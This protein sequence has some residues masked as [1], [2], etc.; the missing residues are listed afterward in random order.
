MFVAVVIAAAVSAASPVRISGV[1][2]DGY[3]QGTPEP[4]SAIRLTNTD[5]DHP[6]PLGGYVLTERLTPKKKTAAL[7]TT[8]S[9][10]SNAQGRERERNDDNPEGVRF[11]Q[12]AVIPPGGELWI[13]ATA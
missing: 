6:A 11:P 12:G 13:A 2:F 4:D 5:P 1:Y 9:N 8:K 10:E 7:T 3:L